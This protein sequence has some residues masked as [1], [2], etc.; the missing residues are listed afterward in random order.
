VG[1]LWPDSRETAALANLRS[2]LKDLRRALGPEAGRLRSSKP[3]TL[4][5][6]LS[7]CEADVV[8]F[9]EAIAQAERDPVG[10]GSDACPALER[11]VALY[12][13]PLLEGCP[14][15]WAFEERQRREQAYLAALE[16]LA[17][18]ALAAEN[19]ETA[20]RYLR[21]AVAVDPLREGAQR[22]ARCSVKAR[23]GLLA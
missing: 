21:R 19:P 16:R 9:D 3:N 13:A 5:L 20:E 10:D 11:A 8:A 15:P 22:A 14:E 12:R 1:L 6:D 7:G 23:G 17:A 4:L 18:Q 2:V